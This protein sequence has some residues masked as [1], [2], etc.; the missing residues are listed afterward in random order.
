LN[1]SIPEQEDYNLDAWR[2]EIFC[3]L[4]FRRLNLGLTILIFYHPMLKL[5]AAKTI[6]RPHLKRN[7]DILK[8]IVIEGFK[9]LQ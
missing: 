6:L 8:K 1:H 7:M 9:T 3:F 2:L 4:G 5:N